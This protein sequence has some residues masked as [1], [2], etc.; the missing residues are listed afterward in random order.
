MKH[1]ATIGIVLFF[2]IFQIKAQSDFRNGYIVKNN[3]DTVYGLINYKG[4]KANAKKCIFKE[5][6]NS[7]KQ[8]YSPEELTSYRFIDS[9]YYISKNI[10]IGNKSEK[11]F[12]EYLINGKV[13][14]YYFR[15]ESGEHYLADKDSSNLYEL[16]DNDKEIIINNTKYIQESK[17]Y[18][19]I[20]KVL[21]KESPLISNRAENVSL[22]HKSLIN[23]ARDY[24]NDVCNDEMCLVYEKKL[25]KI[26]NIYG[27]AIGMNILTISQVANFTDDF[28]YMRNSRFGTKIY[29]SVGL[30]YINSL[31]YVNE[32]LYFQYEGT[33]SHVTLS[34]FNTFY[35]SINNLYYYNDIKLTQ[36]TLNNLII[37][38]HEVAKGKIRP[39]FQIG[40]FVRY[41]FI[42][43]YNR[44]LE[45]KLSNGKTFYANHTDESPFS[46]FDIGINCGIGLKSTYLKNKE[47]Y[48]DVRYQRGFGLMQNLQTNTFSINLG[49]QIGK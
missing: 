20:L 35:E 30:F 18:I 38:K 40:G 48:L 41:S 6:I 49:F 26:K 23:I 42:T 28:Y 13:D 45:I 44:S 9:K 33:Y 24:H 22:N 32:K 31:P 21:F 25:P 12:L 8:T 19:G 7:E 36:N 34:T 5:E 37:L 27:I 39:E 43:N 11:L 46:K 16:R 47:L 29:P 1:L 3:N 2:S 17:E 15:D 14:I 10:N 4:N